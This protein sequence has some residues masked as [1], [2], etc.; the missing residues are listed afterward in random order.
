[1]IVLYIFAVLL[2]SFWIWIRVCYYVLRQ[3]VDN[4]WRFLRRSL[5]PAPYA[6]IVILDICVKAYAIITISIWLWHLF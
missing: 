6:G 1:M 5:I 2:F 4:F 3:P